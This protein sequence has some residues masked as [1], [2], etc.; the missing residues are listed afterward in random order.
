MMSDVVLHVFFFFFFFCLVN[1]KPDLV[2][3]S[4]CKQPVLRSL[5]SFPE[6]DIEF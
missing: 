1:K 5:H 6:T 3:T 4:I 2:A